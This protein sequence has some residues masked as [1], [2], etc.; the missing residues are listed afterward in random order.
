VRGNAAANLQIQGTHL[1]EVALYAEFD[2]DGAM[3]ANSVVDGAAQGVS[4]TN[5]NRG[6]RL[7]I[8]KATSSAI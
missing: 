4:V 2:F 6:G 5:F 3:I 7:A 8:V 1:G